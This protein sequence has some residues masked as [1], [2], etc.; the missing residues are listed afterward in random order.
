M[1]SL[2]LDLRYAFRSLVKTPGFTA[3][4][5]L[6][7]ALGVGANVAIF[8]LIDAVALRSLPVQNPSELA[9]VR[10]VG[11]NGGFGVN[12]G[13]YPQLTRPVWEALKR[14][15]QAFSGMFA[16]KTRELGNGEPDSL[17]PANGIAV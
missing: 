1:D 12:P 13:H 8:Q 6:T 11:G 7:L 9:E 5:V 15:Q 14:D 3:A 17:R 10:I 4:A 16:W 2:L